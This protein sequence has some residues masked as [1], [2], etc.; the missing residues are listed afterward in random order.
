MYKHYF[1]L[2]FFLKPKEFNIE[3]D[4][5][6]LVQKNTKLHLVSKWNKPFFITEY[7]K[8]SVQTYVF[9]VITITLLS[10]V[11]LGFF[12]NGSNGEGDAR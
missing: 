9:C 12:T 6:S 5:D 11:Y 1:V 4:F 10:F 2:Y 3:F 7:S 8:I